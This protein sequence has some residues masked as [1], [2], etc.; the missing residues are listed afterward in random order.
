MIGPRDAEGTSPWAGRTLQPH[1]DVL[2]VI[3]TC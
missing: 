2:I 3:R 1:H